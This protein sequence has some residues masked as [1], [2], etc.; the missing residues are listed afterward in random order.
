VVGPEL[1]VFSGL[2]S[3]NLF[4]TTRSVGA[5][6]R[7]V[8]ERQVSMRTIYRRIRSYGLTSYRLI[9]RFPLTPERR[10]ARLEWCRLRDHWVD[11]WHQIIFSDESQFCLWHSDGRLR[12][13]RPRGQRLNN[14]SPFDAIL[15]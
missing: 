4:E 13:R 2:A 6:W 5:T 10:V 12:D 15:M 14:Y 7:A 1:R 3:V 9:V 11:E 8:L